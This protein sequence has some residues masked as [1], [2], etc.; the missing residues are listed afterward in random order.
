V[1]LVVA[2]L[3]SAD[4]ARDA[5]GAMDL[6]QRLG[7]GIRAAN[8]ANV[9]Y[10]VLVGLQLREIQDRR[11]WQG[12]ARTFEEW[13][14]TRFEDLTG[15]SRETGYVAI[16]LARSP[17]LLQRIGLEGLAEFQTLANIR[18]LVRLER[19][20]KTITDGMI[21]DAK[22]MRMAQFRAEV[23]KKPRQS[24]VG[25]SVENHHA[26]RVLTEIVH[27]LKSADVEAL[28]RL[29]AVIEQIRPIA[30][31]N[32]TDMVDFLLAA[33]E[34][35]LEEERRSSAEASKVADVPWE[36]VAWRKEEYTEDDSNG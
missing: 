2:K 12:E 26:A 5:R 24:A 1:T 25:V 14:S 23:A 32:P 33:A 30:G 8:A 9:L 22:T 19:E 29:A 15:F 34:H 21:E 36:E 16:Q 31:S 10:R 11:L 17:L 18:E 27:K 6:L 35:A 13:I 20:H 28:E 3:G 4:I 7:D